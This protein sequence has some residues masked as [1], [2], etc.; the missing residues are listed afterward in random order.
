MGVEPI[1]HTLEMVGMTGFQPAASRAQGERSKQTELH[2][3]K[4]LPTSNPRAERL[5]YFQRGSV[6]VYSGADLVA[7]WRA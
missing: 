4:G 3:V 1:V 2:S 7:K 6:G 5:R